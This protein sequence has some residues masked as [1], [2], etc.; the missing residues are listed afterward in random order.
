M[1]VTVRVRIS[2]CFPKRFKTNN[3]AQNCEQNFKV[4]LCLYL[5]LCTILDKLSLENSKFERK[6]GGHWRCRLRPK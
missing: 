4:R 2:I 3:I 6:S 1:L 5:D